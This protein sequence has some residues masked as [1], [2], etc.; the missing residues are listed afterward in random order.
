MLLVIK[1][2]LVVF[3]NTLVNTR[4]CIM[5][6]TGPDRRLYN[7]DRSRPTTVYT[8]YTIIQSPQNT[9]KIHGRVL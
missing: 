8:F 5:T 7:Q 1:Q 6:Y 3:Q 2:I 9:L 4:T